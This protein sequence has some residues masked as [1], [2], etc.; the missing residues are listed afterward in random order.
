MKRLIGI[1]HGPL[2]RP[3]SV[4]GKTS[5]GEICQ[6]YAVPGDYGLPTSGIV[7]SGSSIRNKKGEVVGV[8]TENA[9]WREVPDDFGLLPT[10]PFRWD[11]EDMDMEKDDADSIIKHIKD[12]INMTLTQ[13]QA[14]H[15]WQWLSDDMCAGWVCG[16]QNANAV[17]I[18]FDRWADYGFPAQL[19]EDYHDT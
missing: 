17:K 3:I 16:A 5:K 1:R 19:D 2:K 15:F 8:T 14:A 11:T 18:H 9:E 10:A 13:D 12:L 4:K 6:Y 7:K